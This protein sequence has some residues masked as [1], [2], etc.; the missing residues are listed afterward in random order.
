MLS[1]TDSLRAIDNIYRQMILQVAFEH[2]KE[3]RRRD[4]R[5]KENDRT[6]QHEF[7]RKIRL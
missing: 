6:F 4:Q 3:K 2:E 1:E 7:N 5:Y